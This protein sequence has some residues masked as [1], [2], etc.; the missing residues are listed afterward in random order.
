MQY[1]FHQ[2][3]FGSFLYGLTAVVEI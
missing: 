1:E 2:K 3:Y